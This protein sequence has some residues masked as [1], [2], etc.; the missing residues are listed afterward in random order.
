MKAVLPLSC[1]HLCSST[2]LV[3]CTN[4]LGW[5]A[6]TVI[7]VIK[8]SPEKAIHVKILQWSGGLMRSDRK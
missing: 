2:H 6:R 1:G 7:E 4:E 8:W 3:S 5:R